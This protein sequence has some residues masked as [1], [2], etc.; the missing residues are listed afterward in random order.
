MKV[1]LRKNGELQIRLMAGDGID[2]V[3]L[4]RMAALAQN[5]QTVKL[6]KVDGCTVIS[7]E[8]E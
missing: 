2:E 8:A 3:I 4:D 1:E 6:T 5:G 7:M